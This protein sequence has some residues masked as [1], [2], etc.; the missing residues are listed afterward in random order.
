MRG[1][2][3]HNF[4]VCQDS[5]GR[6]YLKFT[7]TISKTN[8][9][10]LKHRRVSP[11][12]AKAY[13]FLDKPAR[14]PVLIFEKYT[15][16]LHP[17]C[18]DENFYYKPAS[19][20]SVGPWFTN[21]V[22]GHNKLKCLVKTV[23]EKADFQGNYTNHSLRVTTATRLFNAGV[24]EQLIKAQT[25]HRSNEVTKYKRPSADQEKNVSEALR[26]KPK[27]SDIDSASAE[28]ASCPIDSLH[29]NSDFHD[30]AVSVSTASSPAS[31]SLSI[32][33]SSG[34]TINIYHK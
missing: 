22:V 34:F 14:C 3:R 31:G 26:K 33:N 19:K 6:R 17:K 10:G 7:E 13:E 16:K 11:H 4:E 12:T 20:V 28:V 24:P 18:S 23:M 1:L 25:G 15:A 27:L 9:G 29:L 5:D 21:C 2:T 32:A 30:M 8:Q